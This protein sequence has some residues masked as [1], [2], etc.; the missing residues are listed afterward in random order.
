MSIIPRRAM[1]LLLAVPLVLGACDD[2][3]TVTEPQVVDIVATARSAG[4][5]STLLTAL[6]VTGLDETLASG[7]P[8]TVFAPTDDAFAALP[9]GTL[10]ALLADTEALTAVLLYHVAE[11]ELSSG[12]VLGSAFVPTLNGQSLAVD[13]SAAR[14]DGS[15]II[16]ADIQATNGV[17]H[18]LDGVLVPAFENIVQIALDNPSFETLATA[19]DVADLAGALQGD[20]PFTVFAPT[21]EAFAAVPPE[22]LQALLA[23]VDALTQVLTYHVV[24]GRL[25]S[26]DV[27]ARAS[28]MTLNGESVNFSLVDG[29]PRVDDANIVSTDIQGT[30]GVIHVIDRVILPAGLTAAA[31]R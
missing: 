12:D 29:T 2:E 5:F 13:G 3:D 20:G 4:S 14:V 24:P 1:P 18:V 19:L 25:L 9:E 7:G 30:N 28:A 31:G 10:D 11:G 15:G 6:E 8:F 23:D 16:Q 27:L 26:S 22:M 17:I 21:N